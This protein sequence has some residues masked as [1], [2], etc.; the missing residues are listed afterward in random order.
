[1]LEE[2]HEEF[3]QVSH[4]GYSTLKWSHEH[5]PQEPQR[6]TAL[7]GCWGQQ[8]LEDMTS[9]GTGFETH[10]IWQ[11]YI[12]EI[13]AKDFVA[14]KARTIAFSKAQ[15][16][17]WNV[18]KCKKPLGSIQKLS[19]KK[20][21]STFIHKFGNPLRIPYPSCTALLSRGLSHARK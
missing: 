17:H 7:L 8:P 1:M 6:S 15:G 21:Q 3:L 18:I 11:G 9:L 14:R 16:T 2:S 19:M 20:E 4:Q 10:A 12:E 13:P 5:E